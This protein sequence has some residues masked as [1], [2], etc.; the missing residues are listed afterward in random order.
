MVRWLLILGVAA[1]GFLALADLGAQNR[2]ATAAGAASSGFDRQDLDLSCQP[3]EDF[4]QYATGGWKK[5]N[6]IGPAYASWERF[7]QIQEGNLT[8]LRRILDMAALER[9]GAEGGGAGGAAA[10]DA[11]GPETL[12]Q[13]LGDYYGACMDEKSIE[14]DGIRPLEPELAR[15][16]AISSPVELQSETARLHRRGVRS[17]FGFGSGQDDKDSTQIIAQAVQGGLGLPDRDYYTKQDA[18]SRKLRDQYRQHIVK[19][20]RLAGEGSAAAERAARTVLALETRL[21]EA[22][23]TRVERRDP[24]ANY[25]KMSLGELREL[26]PAFPWEQYFSDIGFPDI[27][28]VNV[29]QPAFFRALDAQLRATPLDDWKIYLRWHLLRASAPALSSKFVK[30]NFAF[31]NRRLTGVKE[32][33][34]RWRRCV[35]STDRTWARRWGRNTWPARF[36]RKPRPRRKRWWRTWWRRCARTSKRCRG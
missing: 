1:G 16:A 5:R 20:L 6:P 8:A 22:S 11:G 31:Y 13:K 3:C 14:A 19:M 21:A 32:M 4:F 24:Q 23:R 25:N 33:L 10:A 30:E 27:R 12:D 2:A 34:P 36:R 17:M 18:T 9:S 35:N 7:S 28:E 29:G 15:I 26:T